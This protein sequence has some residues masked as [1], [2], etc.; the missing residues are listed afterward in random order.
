MQNLY[1]QEIF[2]HPQCPKIQSCEFAL[3]GTW[4]ITFETESDAMKAYTF[5]QEVAKNFK[6]RNAM[7]VQTLCVVCLNP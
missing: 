5:L 4:Y 1:P 2:N 3:N 7:I 6:V